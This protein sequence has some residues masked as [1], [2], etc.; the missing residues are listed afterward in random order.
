MTSLL[1]KP[2]WKSQFCTYFAHFQVRIAQKIDVEN[3]YHRAN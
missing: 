3:H 2:L 1:G